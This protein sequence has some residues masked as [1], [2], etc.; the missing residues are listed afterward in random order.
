RIDEQLIVRAGYHAGAAADAGVPVQIDDAVA[1][2]VERVGRTNPRAGRVVALVA[3][4]WEEQ[5]AGVGEGAFLDGLDPTAIHADRNL[6]LG[7]AGDRARVTPDA[8][9]KVD[10]EPVFGHAGWRI[11]KINHRD[12]ETQ[13]LDND[14]RRTA[15]RRRRS[16]TDQKRSTKNA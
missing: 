8:L 16:G 7:F 3:E 9:A 2:P 15:A 1:A 4:D 14:T 6:V 5:S 11:Y 12:T 10:G 13:R